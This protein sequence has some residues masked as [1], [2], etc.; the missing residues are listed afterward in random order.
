MKNKTYVT[1]KEAEDESP[2]YGGQSL[3]SIINYEIDKR[4]MR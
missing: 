2:K 3:L 4:M 1:A